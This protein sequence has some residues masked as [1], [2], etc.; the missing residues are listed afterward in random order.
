VVRLESLWFF[1]PVFSSPP[2]PTLFQEPEKQSN[3]NPIVV[4]ISEINQDD[5]KKVVA[6]TSPEE[7]EET[8]MNYNAEEVR[9]E[10]VVFVS[11]P[12]TASER[13]RRVAR[14]WRSKKKTILRE[15][16]LCF[17]SFCYKTYGE[18]GFGRLYGYTA[19]EQR[20]KMMPPLNDSV[21]MK[22]HL[23]SWAHAVACAVK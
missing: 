9:V 8:G 6:Q 5:S 3:N 21:E 4:E 23:K 22:R 20:K 15:L 12:E 7:E 17:D 2:Q 13:K 19:A 18:L 14:R 10:I 11:K 1:T 16:D